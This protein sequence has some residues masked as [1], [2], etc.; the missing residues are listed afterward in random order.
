MLGSTAK[1]WLI[2]YGSQLM[3]VWMMFGKLT[4]SASP[5][6]ER[7]ACNAFFGEKMVPILWG[8]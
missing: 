3:C 4:L 1:Q 5:D 2:C 6:T 8:N 7:K